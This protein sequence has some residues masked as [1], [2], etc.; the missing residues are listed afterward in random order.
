MGFGMILHVILAKYCVKTKFCHLNTLSS[1]V[2][3]KA[4]DI[5]KDIT[6]DIETRFEMKSYFKF[7]SIKKIYR[8]YL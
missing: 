7:K 1:F 3:I 6:E 5:Y 4:D 8:N 2:Y